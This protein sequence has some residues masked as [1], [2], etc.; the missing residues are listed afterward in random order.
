MTK[1]FNARDKYFKKAKS[2]GKRARSYFKIEEV[3]KKMQL[4][5]PGHH[6]LDLGAAP[7]SFLQYA[8]EKVGSG[9]FAVGIDLTPIQSLGGKEH[10]LTYAGDIYEESTKEWLKSAHSA[11]FNGVIS[12]LAPKTTGIKDVDHWNSIELSREVLRYAKTFVKVGGYCVIKIFQGPDFDNFLKSM[13]KYFKQVKL[14]KPDA[15]RDRS[16]EVYL[17]GIGRIEQISIPKKA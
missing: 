17:V 14:E 4:I 9:G 12:D 1:P 13:K 8:L 6:V 11:L 5:R 10:V 7:G 2:Q 15:S 3:D 16:K